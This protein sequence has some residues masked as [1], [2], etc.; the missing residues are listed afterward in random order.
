[1]AGRLITRFRIFKDYGLKSLD[2]WRNPALIKSALPPFPYVFPITLIRSWPP[3]PY[4]GGSG[5]KA[6]A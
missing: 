1:M 2:A 5:G 6:S 3:G 4:F